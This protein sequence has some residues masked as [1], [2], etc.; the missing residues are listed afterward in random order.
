MNNLLIVLTDKYPFG[1]GETFVE[2][3]RLYW[4]RAFDSILIC[5]VLATAVDKLRKGFECRNK[6]ALIQA[7]DAKPTISDS[8]ININGF[9]SI[10]AQLK[11]IR[12]ATELQVHRVKSIVATAVYSNMRHERILNEILKRI[13]INDGYQICVYAYWM[14]EPA[15]VGA[16][17]CKDLKA[18]HFISRAHGYD[19]YEERQ[20]YHYFPFRQFVLEQLDGIYPISEDGKQYLCR[21][22]PR[23]KSKVAVARLGTVKLYNDIVSAKT[24]RSLVLVSCSNLVPLKRV[25]RIIGVL[26]QMQQP[27]HWYHFGDGELREELEKQAKMLPNNIESTFMGRIPND[28]VQ[29]FYSENFI[30]AFI[31]VSETEGIPVSIMEAQSYGI[32]IIATDVGGTHEIVHDGVNGAL[33]KSDFTDKDFL[34]ALNQVLDNMAKFRVE[35]RKIW[36]QM[37][38]ANINYSLFFGL[39]T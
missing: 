11:E 30:D 39:K 27:V 17:L 20:P 38:N 16:A 2:A 8:I 37:S 35:S 5:P 7:F 23:V 24:E 34:D 29:K 28:K 12:E 19:L 18:K 22:Y 6:E 32:P 25:G 21:K 10:G 3:E 31:N 13:D 36:N 26:S 15:L 9:Y 1:Q 14:Y 4:E 33:L